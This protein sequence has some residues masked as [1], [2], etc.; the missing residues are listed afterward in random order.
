MNDSNATDT[1]KPQAHGSVKT[2]AE[3][4][5]RL[6]AELE[7]TQTALRQKEAAKRAREASQAKKNRTQALI[8]MGI[9][10]SSLLREMTPDAHEGFRQIANAKHAN[11]IKAV[12]NLTDAKKTPDQIARYK[13]KKRAILD[14]QHALLLATMQSAIAGTFK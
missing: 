8:L 6:K 4:A 5:A 14:R 11:A 7:A 1:N 3:K 12:E 9:L 10:F 13:A 2:L